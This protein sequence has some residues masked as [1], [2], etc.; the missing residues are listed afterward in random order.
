MPTIRRGGQTVT[1]AD[2]DARVADMAPSLAG[3]KAALMAEADRRRDAGIFGGSVLYGSIPVD[4]RSQ[5][6]RDNLGDLRSFALAVPGETIIAFRDAENVTHSLT[7]LQ[8]LDL[9]AL[10]LAHG[11]AWYAAAWAHKDA[12]TALETV[13]TAQAYDLTEGWP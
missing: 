3:L 8:V 10:A 4:L 11:Q 6:D 7:A 1:I 5:R 13:A 12:I 9:T 2:D